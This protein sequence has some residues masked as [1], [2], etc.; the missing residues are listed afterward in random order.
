MIN[1]IYVI[2]LLLIIYACS[3][4]NLIQEVE[5]ES[6][7]YSI[8]L[9]DSNSFVIKSGVKV[10]LLKGFTEELLKLGVDTINVKVEEYLSIP[11]FIKNDLLT[12]T[13]K[14][15]IL[16]SF[17]MY[18]LTALDIS[19]QITG[20]ENCFRLTVSLST[21]ISN[22][23]KYD[24]IESHQNGNMWTNPQPISNQGSNL[25][26]SEGGEKSELTNYQ[27]DIP[28]NKLI[29]ID[30]PI[31]KGVDKIKLSLDTSKEFEFKSFGIV[32]TD[33]NSYLR[34]FPNENGDYD[35]EIPINTNIEVFCVGQ[36]QD[37][38]SFGRTTFNTEQSKKIILTLIRSTDEEIQ[39]II[40][41]Y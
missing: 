31:L 37:Q 20:E 9:S 41:T 5:E 14:D 28:N 1:K 19:P 6:L 34:A 7:T 8:S 2:L 33:F 15:E 21:Q 22:V 38:I 25:I 24:V 39:K 29:N 27:I 35:I 16:H 32:F 3:S 12:L 17:G 40:E 13:D 4:N 36:D 11:S 26:E 18:R 10:E 30:A 23:Q